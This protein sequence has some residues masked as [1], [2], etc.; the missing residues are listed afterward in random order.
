M[1]SWGDVL[2]KKCSETSEPNAVIVSKQ[3]YR[4]S[5]PHPHHQRSLRHMCFGLYRIVIYVYFTFTFL[6]VTCW[7]KLAQIRLFVQIKGFKIASLTCQRATCNL[8][9]ITFKDPGSG[10]QLQCNL[11]NE[12]IRLTREYNVVSCTGLC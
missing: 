1:R 5:F 12:F 10:D 4:P 2:K 6:Y 9:F 7:S 11:I 8:V 3:L